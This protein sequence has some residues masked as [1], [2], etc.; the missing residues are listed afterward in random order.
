LKAYLDI[1]RDVI[2]N[3]ER[4]NNRT[5]IDT[6]VM[7]NRV[8]SHDMSKGF[9]LLT[10][11]KMAFKTLSV[12]LEGFINGITSKKWYQERGC[13]IWDEWS[14][15]EAKWKGE[16]SCKVKDWPSSMAIDSNCPMTLEEEETFGITHKEWIQKEH[17][18]AQRE[19][20]D[21]GPIYGYQWR[22]FNKPY[23][24][25]RYDFGEHI[26]QLANIIDTLKTNPDDRRMVCSAW[27]PEQI[28]LMALP[29]CHYSWGLTHI[30]GTLHMHWEQ[31][32]CDLFLGVPFNIASYALLLEIICKTV[33]MKPG[34]L[35]GLL[36]DCHIYE[37]QMEQCFEQL[38]RTPKTL[39]TIEIT[40]DDIF[41][42]THK[43]VK[44]I[45]YQPHGAIKAEVAV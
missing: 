31:R 18:R 11:K 14:N 36:I 15:P 32:S 30:N 45:G 33:G 27:N 26:D 9:P 43:D 1:V 29:P 41:K 24:K 40:C 2:R 20:D 8:F 39:P 16:K 22:H 21:L 10:T 44:L 37:N 13:H 6:I 5:G 23:D 25:D 42:W 3:G 19:C 35:T 28:H 7:P 4:K 38:K 17:K 34:N 12:E